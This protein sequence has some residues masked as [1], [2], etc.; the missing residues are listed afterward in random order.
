MHKLHTNAVS[1]IKCTL[2]KTNSRI[3]ET[4]ERIREVENIIM[5][6]IEAERGKK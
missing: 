1:E 2:E 3:T 6:I 4:D 5:E